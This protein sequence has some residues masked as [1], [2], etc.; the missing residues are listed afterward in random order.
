MR[1]AIIGV[2]AGRLAADRV[3]RLAARPHACPFLMSDSGTI[4]V[5]AECVSVA[6]LPTLAAAD[7]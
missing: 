5:I 2:F 4:S 7:T 3:C 1:Y 6:K